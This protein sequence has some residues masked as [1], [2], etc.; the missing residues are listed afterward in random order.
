MYQQDELEIQQNRYSAMAV[1][2]GWTPNTTC[3]AILRRQ[4]GWK[5]HRT[6]LFRNLYLQ[7]L[8]LPDPI[9]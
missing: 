5:N 3:Q 8:S 6:G 2:Y 1:G 7:V 9:P 4:L